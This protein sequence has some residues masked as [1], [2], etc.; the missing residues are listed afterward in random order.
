MGELTRI[1]SCGKSMTTQGLIDYIVAE[2]ISIDAWFPEK[3]FIV[4]DKWGLDVPLTEWEIL[5]RMP[6]LVGKTFVTVSEVPILF[7]LREVRKGRMRT[8]E[9]ELWCGDRLIQV[10]I[11]GDMVDYWDGGFFELGFNLRFH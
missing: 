2:D 10:G 5:M 9:L 3:K 8:D 7:C 11:T 1:Y 4:G 6:Q